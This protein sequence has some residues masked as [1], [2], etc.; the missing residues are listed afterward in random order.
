MHK[1][2]AQLSLVSTFLDHV[3]SCQSRGR[4][5][6]DINTVQLPAHHQLPEQIRNHPVYIMV[7]VM[8]QSHRWFPRELMQNSTKGREEIGQMDLH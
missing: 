8:T 6:Q 3:A 1:Y 4:S 7:H 5:L 2:A